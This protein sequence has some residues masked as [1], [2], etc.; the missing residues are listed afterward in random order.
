[1]IAVSTSLTNCACGCLG[2]SSADNIVMEKPQRRNTASTV[3]LS[4]KDGLE[5]DPSLTPEDVTALTNSDTVE[6]LYLNKPYISTLPSGLSVESEDPLVDEL[7]R[8]ND[9]STPIRLSPQ[10]VMASDI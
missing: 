1:M 5:V 10:P 7:L 3:S 9:H 8:D 6:K 2:D 4:E